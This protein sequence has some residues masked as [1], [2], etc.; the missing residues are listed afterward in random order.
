M[1]IGIYSFLDSNKDYIRTNHTALF[2]TYMLTGV[3]IIL[4]IIAIIA[5][6]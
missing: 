3:V 5:S 2:Y 1:L 4:M 6:V